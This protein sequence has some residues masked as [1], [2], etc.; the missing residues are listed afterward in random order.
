MIPTTALSMLGG[1]GAPSISDST[2]VSFDPTNTTGKTT[3]WNLN[4]KNG[5]T[6]GAF[7]LATLLPVAIV[8][9]VVFIVWRLLK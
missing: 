4:I 3:S 6:G 5:Q 2:K 9:A 1:G 7:D 8:L